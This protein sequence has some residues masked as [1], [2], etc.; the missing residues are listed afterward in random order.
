MGEAPNLGAVLVRLPSADSGLVV[1]EYPVVAEVVVV[2]AVLAAVAQTETVPPPVVV[3]AVVVAEVE[4]EVVA[5]VVAEV[6]A[7]VL[8]EAVLQAVLLV[9]PLL[10]VLAEAEAE[11]EAEASRLV[12]VIDPRPALSVAQRLQPLLL[13][14]PL[15]HPRVLAPLLATVAVL[16]DRPHAQEPTLHSIVKQTRCCL[17]H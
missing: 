10:L 15:P 2:E 17:R 4:V 14:C 7:K 11:A 9:S 5:V 13:L 8:E 12:F 1:P 6:V 3:A 16:P